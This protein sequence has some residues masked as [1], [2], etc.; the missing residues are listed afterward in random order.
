MDEGKY[1]EYARKGEYV[2]IVWDELD[3]LS[4]LKETTPERG[5]DDLKKK[6]KITFPKSSAVGVGLT[7]AQ[8]FN[9]VIRLKRGDIILTPTDGKVLLGEVT[10]EYF[11]VKTPEDGCPFSNRR[12]VDW[13]KEVPKDRLSERLSLL[14]TLGKRFLAWKLIPS[15]SISYSEERLP[16]QYRK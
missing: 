11:Y 16:L 3:D 13:K 14:F 7:S 9:F 15:K 8:I 1:A 2:A 6:C 5:L 4:W 12:S 10:G